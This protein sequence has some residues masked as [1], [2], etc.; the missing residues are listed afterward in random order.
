MK[1]SERNKDNYFR[2]YKATVTRPEMLPEIIPEYE[3][4]FSRYPDQLR[5]SFADGTT[6]VYQ[7]K[8][9][10]PAPLIQRNIQIIR[11]WKGYTPPEER[12]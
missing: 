6:I 11:K 5:I 8:V 2:G 4:Q 3:D 10:L 12:K 7:V 1:R 9:S